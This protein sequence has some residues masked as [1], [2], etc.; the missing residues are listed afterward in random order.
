MSDSTAVSM[1]T[2]IQDRLNAKLKDALIDLIPPEIL[3]EKSAEATRYF[4]HGRTQ[5]TGYDAEQR[6]KDY[7]IENDSDTLVGM[8][9]AEM[10]KLATEEV[11]K[12]FEEHE[13]FK[14]LF[15]NFGQPMV[16]DFVHKFIIENA[17]EVLAQFVGGLLQQQLSMFKAN[18][19]QSLQRGY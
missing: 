14:T 6:R 2:T 11:K 18:M 7:R 1:Q 8:I 16:T 19:A 3:K 13:A 9:H 15:S 12:A 4:L 17:G 5:F 10:K